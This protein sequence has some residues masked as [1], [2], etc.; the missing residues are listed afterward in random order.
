MANALV[1]VRRQLAGVSDEE[2]ARARKA[3][4]V[5][6]EENQAAFNQAVRQVSSVRRPERGGVLRGVPS[7]PE[8]NAPVASHRA[9]RSGGVVISRGA[10]PVTDSRPSG[11]PGG[12]SP[13]PE[14]NAPVANH[15]AI[16]PGR[17]V[18][19]RGAHP[20][21]DSRPSGGPGAG[22]SPAGRENVAEQAR[23]ARQAQAREIAREVR[24][25]SF[26]SEAEV[27]L[28]RVFSHVIVSFGSPERSRAE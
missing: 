3:A 2:L 16:R 8:P 15:R 11:V 10:H 1:V 24:I 6:L 22:R 17:V 9:T 20:V 12:V 26:G 28:R 5:A 7:V 21:A 18:I 13:V 14:P 27:T 4:N 23:Q 19:S 25:S